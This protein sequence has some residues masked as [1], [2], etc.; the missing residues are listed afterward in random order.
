MKK[1]LLTMTFLLL[2][3]SALAQEMA[4]KEFYAQMTSLVSL[5]EKGAD[6]FVHIGEKDMGNGVTCYYINK[7]R[8]PA[9]QS[10]EAA[11][12]CLKVR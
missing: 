1:S 7:A 5:K 4:A 6:S 12:S 2:A 3:G 9:S 8:T 11:L 10:S